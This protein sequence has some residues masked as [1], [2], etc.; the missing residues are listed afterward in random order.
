MSRELKNDF[1]RLIQFISEYSLADMPNN[2]DFT[3]I[4]NEMH[5]RYFSILTFFMN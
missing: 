3:G 1:G 4:L 5:R 2:T